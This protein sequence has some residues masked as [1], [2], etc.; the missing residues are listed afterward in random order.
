MESKLASFD[1]KKTLTEMCSEARRR[2]NLL[3]PDTV[4]QN[5]QPKSSKKS[6]VNKEKNKENLSTDAIS[7]SNTLSKLRIKSTSNLIRIKI[8]I[9]MKFIRNLT[10][11]LTFKRSKETRLCIMIEINV[12]FNI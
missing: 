1:Y 5:P 6:K 8:T 9:K 7:Q 4:F 12:I 11:F 10:F 3:N 2:L